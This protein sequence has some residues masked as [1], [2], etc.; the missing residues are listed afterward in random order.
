MS[1]MERTLAIRVRAALTERILRE[2]GLEGQVTAA[3]G[4]LKRPKGTTLAKGI[5]SMFKRSPE[6]EWRAH[7]EA[8]VAELDKKV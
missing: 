8:V 1:R 5:G 2:C 3:L 6:R 4:A 7:I